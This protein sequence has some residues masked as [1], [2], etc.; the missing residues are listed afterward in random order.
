MVKQQPTQLTTHSFETKESFKNPCC[1][2]CYLC[3]CCGGLGMSFFFGFCYLFLT[4]LIVQL[5]SPSSV[6]GMYCLWNLLRRHQRNL[7]LGVVIHHSCIQL[8]VF[9]PFT[10]SGSSP[11]F[12]KN[13]FWRWTSIQLL[14]PSTFLS[15]SLFFRI[16]SNIPNIFFLQ[17]FC[18]GRMDIPH[19]KMP[20]PKYL[21]MLLLPLNPN[22]YG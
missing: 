5:S 9:P 7:I 14:I 1:C 16:L 8:F 6:F 15:P 3:A 10:G 19:S 2:P 13:Q 11:K 4:Q 12:R 20:K 17:S 18:F 21:Q 22:L